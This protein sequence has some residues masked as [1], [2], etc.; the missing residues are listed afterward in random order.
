M[1]EGVNKLQEE[2]ENLAQNNARL[3]TSISQLEE[4][5]NQVGSPLVRCPPLQP[6]EWQEGV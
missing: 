6:E 3:G 1:T 4:V 5:K 2:N